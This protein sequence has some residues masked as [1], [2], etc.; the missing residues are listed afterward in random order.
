MSHLTISRPSDRTSITRPFTLLGSLATDATRLV[1]EANGRFAPD[2]VG[3]L[4]VYANGCLSVEVEDGEPDAY[5]AV[6][7]ARPDGTVLIPLCFSPTVLD[8]DSVRRALS[9]EHP[10][11]AW[12]TLFVGHRQFS[13][14]ADGLAQHAHVTDLAVACANLATHL[15]DP[16]REEFFARALSTPELRA[17]GLADDPRDPI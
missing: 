10:L 8:L 15:V 11:G 12:L 14:D 1:G 7:G 5:T 17:L 16:L 3:Y 6:W 4:A 13:T 9:P 2:Q